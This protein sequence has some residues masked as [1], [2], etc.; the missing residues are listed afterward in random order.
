MSR[1]KCDLFGVT[2][3]N[4]VVLSVLLSCYPDAIPGIGWNRRTV[5]DADAIPGIGRKGRAMGDAETICGVAAT[6]RARHGQ[7][8]RQSVIESDRPELKVWLRGAD[9]P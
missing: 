1:P 6:E 3:D 9:P 7:S 2:S 4:L 8:L 5:G